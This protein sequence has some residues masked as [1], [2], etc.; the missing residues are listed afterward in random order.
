M[1]GIDYA[2]IEQTITNGISDGIV[3]GFAVVKEQ[4]DLA[5]ARKTT[6]QAEQLSPADHGFIKELRAKIV[7]LYELGRQDHRAEGDG[8]YPCPKHSDAGPNATDDCDC[9]A[10]DHNAKL[11]EIME[12]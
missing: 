3:R 4:A 11:L 1:M 8:N 7:D 2:M 5:E 9:G 6:R 12:R 10:R